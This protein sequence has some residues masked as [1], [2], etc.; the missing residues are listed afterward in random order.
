M[1]ALFYFIPSMDYDPIMEIRKMS[2]YSSARTQPGN[3]CGWIRSPTLVVK[4]PPT[5]TGDVRDTGSI[6]GSGR[7]PGI[8]NGNP[9]QYSCLKNSLDRG[10]WWAVVHEVTESDMTEQM[11]VCTHEHART[12]TSMHAHTQ[13]RARAHTHTHTSY[14]RDHP[15]NSLLYHFPSE[16]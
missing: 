13:A 14:S 7:S 5:N 10:A 15:L 1:L 8:G 12:H 11:S 6:P 3:C 4:K 16:G 2:L 9:F